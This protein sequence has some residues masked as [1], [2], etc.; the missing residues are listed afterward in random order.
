LDRPGVVTFVGE[1]I[2]AGV[3]K[4][5]RMRLQ[6]EAGAGYA[7]VGLLRS[8]TQGFNSITLAPNVPYDQGSPPLGP[9][10]DT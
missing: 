10:F 1:C 3:A 9:A 6:L 2:A 8:S 4:H 5:V 7:A